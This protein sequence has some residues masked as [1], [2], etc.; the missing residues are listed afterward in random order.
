MVNINAK[1]QALVLYVL[2]SC[3]RIT[4]LILESDLSENR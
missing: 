2:F 4:Y 3:L 1:M